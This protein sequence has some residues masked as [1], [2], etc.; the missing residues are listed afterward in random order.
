[1]NESYANDFQDFEGDTPLHD[2]IHRGRDDIIEILM[3]TK[4][5]RKLV[6][7]TISNDKGFNPLHL[8][9]KNGNAS[10]IR[11]ILSKVPRVRY[12][13]PIYMIFLAAIK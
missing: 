4:R 6:D 8:A 1:M 10:A 11:L 7:V 9:A 3:E 2:A 13:N 12:D 5:G